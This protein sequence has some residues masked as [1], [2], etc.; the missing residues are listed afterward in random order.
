MAALTIPYSTAEAEVQV[1]SVIKESTADFWTS[2]EIQ[3]W[4]VEGAAGFS[5]M[6]GLYESVDDL[7][8]VANQIEYTALDAGESVADIVRIHA[9]VYNDGSNGYTGL[10][11]LGP[12]VI[13]R[14]DYED[15]GDPEGYTLFAEKLIISPIT[16]AAIVTAG[17]VVR[18]YYSKMADSITDLPDHLQ[19]FVTY[20]AI[21]MAF[22]KLG[23]NSVATQFLTMY[24]NAVMF[25]RSDLRISATTPKGMFDQPDI[26]V[27]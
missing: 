22:F 25:E 18:V 4:L 11:E 1:R 19:Q 8:L 17:G 14:R 15:A 21:A 9:A 5:T 12:E 27:V 23:K 13:G 20:Y 26:S 3:S 16:T 6:S 7:T 24:H 10:A 2:D